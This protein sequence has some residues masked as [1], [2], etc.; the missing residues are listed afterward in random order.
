MTDLMIN[1]FKS[2]FED[3]A[4]HD[5]TLLGIIL[6]RGDPGRRDEVALIIEWPDGRRD[7]L[8][9]FDCYSLNAQMNF[10]IIALESIFDAS[11][12]TE[13]PEITDV[14]E[15]WS[16]S[17]VDFSDLLFFE[18]VPSTVGTIRIVARGFR[19]SEVHDGMQLGLRLPDRIYEADD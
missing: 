6:D 7:R 13:A 8:V 19:V 1:Q 2:Q 5:A 4:W 15:T 17:G 18:I 14:R 16:R 12:S 3:F 9:F 10:G 11:C